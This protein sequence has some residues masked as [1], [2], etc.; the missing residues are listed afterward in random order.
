MSH[1]KSG[2]FAATIAILVLAAAG[3]WAYVNHDAPAQQ[4]LIVETGPASPDDV[5]VS[6]T[7]ICLPHRDEHKR[8][9]EC[10]FGLRTEDGSNYAVDVTSINLGVLQDMESA[11][12]IAV[13]GTFVPLEAVASDQWLKYDIKG[14]I[15][16]ETMYAPAQL[17]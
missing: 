17:L 6:G 11:E 8:L 1:Q 16:A 15:R 2:L 9:L 12:R 10:A 3:A 7:A 5:S 14:I 4:S 13:A